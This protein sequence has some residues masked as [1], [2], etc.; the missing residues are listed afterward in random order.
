VA[1]DKGLA[2]SF[3]TDRR[4]SLIEMQRELYVEVNNNLLL[5][6]FARNVNYDDCL[7]L[8]ELGELL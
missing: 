2:R 8:L 4:L 3:A 7:S 5:A 6:K 1:E